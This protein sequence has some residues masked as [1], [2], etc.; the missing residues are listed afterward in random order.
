MGQFIDLTGQQF[1]E[2][3]VIERV[4]NQGRQLQ[5]LC[6]CNCGQETVVIGDHLKNSHTQSCGCL[7]SKTAIKTHSKHG[8]YVNGK[9]SRI[10]ESW[11]S[12]IQRCTNPNHKYWEDYG[13]R[14]ITICEEWLEFT[15]FLKDMKERPPGCTIERRE[16]EEG[17]SPENCY[18]AT[19]RQ[20]AR[21]MRKNRLETYDGKTQCI[22]AWAEE[23]NLPSHTLWMRLYKLGWSIEKALMT[24]VGKQGK[25]N[26]G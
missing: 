18:W 12:M 21:N 25:Q 1:G 22:A 7:R 24:P 4:N 13:G 17:Y 15:N 26:N 2:L 23:Y 10:Y 20:Q 11:A 19:R 8:H 5:W 9:Q 14:G 3:I 6:L 16:N